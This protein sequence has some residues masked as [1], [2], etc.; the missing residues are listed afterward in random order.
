[1]MWNTTRTPERTR[2]GA[3]EPRGLAPVARAG[4]IADAAGTTFTAGPYP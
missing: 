2:I 4:W 3:R 1:M